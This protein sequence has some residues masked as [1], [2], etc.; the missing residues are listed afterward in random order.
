MS[1][2]SGSSG[3]QLRARSSGERE[4]NPRR[5]EGFF[6]GEALPLPA[7]EYL[8]EPVARFL[9]ADARAGSDS[10][11]IF[12]IESARS[13]GPEATCPAIAIPAAIL[14]VVGPVVGEVL[15]REAA[16]AGGSGGCC[17]TD[18]IHPTLPQSSQKRKEA[19]PRRERA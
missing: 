10:R 3:S 15:V 19:R 9:S 5:S 11:Q 16:P 12:L 8:A 2:S 7:S 6:E 18:S 1:F 14:Q 13:S 17:H 4:R